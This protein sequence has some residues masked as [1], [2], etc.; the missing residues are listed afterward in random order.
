M[1]KVIQKGFTLV[2]L[3]ISVAIIGI[4]AS[5]AL[6]IYPNYVKRSRVAEGLNLA[7]GIKTLVSE[8]LASQNA[9][10]ENNAALGLGHF[11]QASSGSV[12]QITVERNKVI[13]TFNEKVDDGK[14]IIFVGFLSEGSITWS[15]TGGTLPSTV[16]PTQCRP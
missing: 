15:C 3:M 9:W 16:R 4:L 7:S 2:E 14:D 6:N 8:H 11:N 13:V 12:R 5:S 10:P 1:A